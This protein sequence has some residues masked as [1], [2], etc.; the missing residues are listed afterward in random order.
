[1]SSYAI[2]K[3]NHEEEKPVIN[4]KGFMERVNLGE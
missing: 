4:D 2:V 1:M 3:Y